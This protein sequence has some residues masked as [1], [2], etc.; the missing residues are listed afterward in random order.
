MAAKKQVQKAITVT[1]S[2]ANGQQVLALALKALGTKCNGQEAAAIGTDCDEARD[3][4]TAGDFE[5]TGTIQFM[6]KGKIGLDTTANK[7]Y[8]FKWIEM[9][10]MA[11]AYSGI[12]RKAAR[13]M[14][15]AMIQARRDELAFANS[16]E[17]RKA[18]LL[19]TITQ[20]LGEVA[21]CVRLIAEKV[22]A[23]L[24]LQT[25]TYNAITVNLGDGEE[26]VPA[27]EVERLAKLAAER[28]AEIESDGKQFAQ[29]LMEERPVRGSVT[30]AE[31][32]IVALAVEA[33][34]TARQVA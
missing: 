28:V 18:A 32:N 31:V 17:A 30:F 7:A 1:T 15:A 16:F 6:A 19:T 23:A 13:R 2:G 27:A 33:E 3:T 14:L 12:T 29:L 34:T 11:L 10:S 4:L 8:G 24:D 21:N 9:L 5:V 26:T 25:P 22:Q 20:E